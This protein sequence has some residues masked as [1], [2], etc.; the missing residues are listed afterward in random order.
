VVRRIKVQ[1]AAP[2]GLS[3]SAYECRK[4]LFSVALSN[5]MEDENS[6]SFVHPYIRT[7]ELNRRFTDSDSRERD[8][9]N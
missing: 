6:R 7:K 3:V 8:A 2:P 1:R 4:V 9:S 5:S